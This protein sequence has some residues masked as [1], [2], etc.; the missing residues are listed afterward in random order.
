L[1][2]SKSSRQIPYAVND[3][4]SASALRW[5]QTLVSTL[6]HF[7]KPAPEVFGAIVGGFFWGALAWR[8]RSLLPG[9]YQHWLL[10]AV[11][12]FSIFRSAR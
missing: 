5:V 11:L 10:G 8:T 3:Q 9:I 6:A 12:D 4:F 2:R 7:G 1:S